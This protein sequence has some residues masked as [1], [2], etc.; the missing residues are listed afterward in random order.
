MNLYQDQKEGNS[1]DLLSSNLISFFSARM[2]A[3]VANVSA[4]N[5]DIEAALAQQL[6]AENLPFPGKKELR[7]YYS[8]IC[9][10]RTSYSLG[11][12]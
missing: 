2:D 5:F 12:H 10:F 4:H 1:P 7:G 6:G 9:Y 3:V 8:I 11:I